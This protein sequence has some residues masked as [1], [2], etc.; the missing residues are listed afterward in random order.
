MTDSQ[1]TPS[2]DPAR[3]TDEA[4]TTLVHPCPAC[5]AVYTEEELTAA[6][7][8]CSKCGLELA[9][10][11]P[12]G[13]G[14]TEVLAW[15]RQPGE[16]LLDR[17]R[18]EKILGKGGFATTYLV[19]DNKLN[20]R[21]RAIKE[22]PKPLYDDLE[23]SMLSQLNHPA[24]PD[25]VDRGETDD[26]IYLV[27]KFG[28]GRTLENERKSH[29]G[30]VSLEVFLP[31][32]K[33][34]SDAISYLHHQQPPIIHRDLKPEN[35]LLDEHDRVM[36][37]DFGIAKQTDDDGQTRVIAR[38]A[39]H[40]FSPPE[41]ALGTGTEPRSDVYSLAATAYVMLTGQVPP[42]A[43]IRVAGRELTPPAQLVPDLPTHI[44]DA[45]VDALNLNIQLRPQSVQALMQRITGETSPIADFGQP[46]SRTVM[47]GDLPSTYTEQATSVRIGTESISVGPIA[48]APKKSRKG[49]WMLMVLLLAAAGG[50]YLYQQGYL[51]KLL[52]RQPQQAGNEQPTSAPAPAQA[53]PQP[54]EA[55]QH[56]VANQTASTPITPNTAPLTPA[57]EVTPGQ[58]PTAAQIEAWR[59]AQ[60]KGG[61]ATSPPTAATPPTTTQP[62]PAVTSTPAAQ[63]PATTAKTPAGTSTPPTATQAAPAPTGPWTMARPP[64]HAQQQAYPSGSA[65]RA[66]SEQWRNNPPPV[67][68]PPPVTPTTT[69]SPRVRSSSTAKST[70]QPRPHST[71]RR[72]QPKASSSGWGA[73]FKGAT[74]N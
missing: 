31:W 35:V 50:G 29:S 57:P 3:M 66:L 42:P 1:V 63:T 62:T 24:I 51:D 45:L 21:H 30:R 2:D 25:I 13:N 64:V 54:P 60:A 15:L 5:G 9:H 26:T 14:S 32:F 53:T 67:S 17:Y 20:G 28:G 23:E 43:H 61:A 18:I 37:I 46:T 58:G 19:K 34:L 65:S 27:L 68:A 47:V 39:T 59:R 16:M 12:A 11:R 71:T 44:S 8:R 69:P 6:D 7:Y 55:S 74:H 49:L 52:N 48:A 22:I 56:A 72:H 38:A 33:Q 73:K 41:Q 70:P 36:L 40:G 4:L 10:T